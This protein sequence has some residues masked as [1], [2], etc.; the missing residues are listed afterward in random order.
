ML[1]NIVESGLEMVELD[2]KQFNHELSFECACSVSTTN[3]LIVLCIYRS[4]LGDINVFYNSMHQVL[5]HIF[6]QYTKYTIIVA[7]DF[8]ICL[9]NKSHEAVKF[10]DMVKQFGLIQTIYEPTRVTKSTSSLID[11]IFINDHEVCTGAVQH[12]RII[13]HKR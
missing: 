11:N 13:M 2:L 9:L 5:E 6:R 4:Q 1:H 7:G 10:T 12:S 3:K 8:N